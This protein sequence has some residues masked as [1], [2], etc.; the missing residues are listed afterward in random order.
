M[1]NSAKSSPGKLPTLTALQIVQQKMQP[2]NNM[3]LD[4][5]TSNKLV[6]LEDK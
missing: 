2:Q 5:Y 3:V 6:E 4:A 1:V